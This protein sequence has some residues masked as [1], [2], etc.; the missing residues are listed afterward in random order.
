MDAAE[1]LAR[2]G[3]ERR[4]P[5]LGPLALRSSWP[6]QQRV[7]FGTAIPATSELAARWSRL[8]TSF[9]IL[10]CE[11]VWEQRV[12]VR[13]AAIDWSFQPLV[14]DTREANVRAA[15]W[16]FGLVRAFEFLFHTV[17]AR[18]VGAFADA[19][20]YIDV[21]DRVRVGFFADPALRPSEMR[22]DST[23]CGE[24][25]LVHVLGRVLRGLVALPDGH[26]FEAILRRCAAPWEKRYATLAEVR[27]AVIDA[28]GAVPS[29]PTSRVWH[30][31]D[32]LEAGVGF[33]LAGAPEQAYAAL[34]RSL[35]E[36]PKLALAKELLVHAARL[37]PESIVRDDARHLTWT[38]V[39]PKVAAL[40]ARGATQQAMALLAACPAT[41]DDAY[42]RDTMLAR[43]ALESGQHFGALEAIDRLLAVTPDDVQL[44]QHRATALLAVGNARGALVSVDAWI[45]GAPGDAAAHHLRG[46]VLGQLGRPHE[47]RDAFD[48]ASQLAPGNVAAA[49]MRT[50]LDRKGKSLRALVGSDR[51]RELP[52]PAHLAEL[53]PLLGKGRLLDAILWL[54]DRY[55]DVDARRLLATCHEY[56]GDFD[57]ALAIHTYDADPAGTARCLIALGR[58][59]EALAL[60]LDPELRAEALEALGRTEEAAATRTQVA[61][62]RAMLPP[63]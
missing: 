26:P 44:Q 31:W 5:A 58:A 18:H 12:E 42:A 52:V 40:V 21:L 51:Y 1:C 13:Y 46:K 37:S 63:T 22:Q 54:T 27:T 2:V 60:D 4:A 29:L 41:D 30:A 49:V 16:A 45:A 48:R 15:R 11:G 62:T 35:R 9:D 39:A 7:V 25:E 19:S 36:A 17:G 3:W 55:A 56:A 38:E 8:K 43:L 61:W 10:V 34:V 14:L 53:G 6:D 47:A 57:A 20:V 50:N 23:I 28:L 24:C 59:G 33:L 32:H